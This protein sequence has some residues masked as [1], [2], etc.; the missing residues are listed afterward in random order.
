M[1]TVRLSGNRAASK[2]PFATAREHKRQPFYFVAP[3]DLRSH[4]NGLAHRFRNALRFEHTLLRLLLR[5]LCAN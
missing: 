5:H 4:R 2:N 1:H 3:T